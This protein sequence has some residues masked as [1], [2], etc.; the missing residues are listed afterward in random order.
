MR[1]LLF[2][3][4]LQIAAPAELP[5]E[6]PETEGWPSIMTNGEGEP[7]FYD[8]PSA[9]LKTSEMFWFRRYLEEGFACPK[10]DEVCR[11]AVVYTFV[12]DSD[13]PASYTQMV[14]EIGCIGPRGTVQ[15]IIWQVRNPFEA[16]VYSLSDGEWTSRGRYDVAYYRDLKAVSRVFRDA[17]AHERASEIKK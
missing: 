12:S 10:N 8:V 16:R 7:L 4:L 9:Q 3:F 13:D 5:S 15:S 17:I 6:L 1:S 11:V 2:V 14:G